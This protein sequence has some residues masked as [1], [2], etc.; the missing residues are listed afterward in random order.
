MSITYHYA[1]VAIA[2]EQLREKGF[3]E[4]FNLEG[5]YLVSQVG[6]FGDSDFEIEHVYFYEGES[7]PDDEATVYG[8]QSGSGH[9][10]VL[11]TGSDVFADNAESSIIKKLLHHNIKPEE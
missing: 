7:N 3:T 1:T 2:I 6:R 8:I 5:N 11:V 9:K 4:D 10:G